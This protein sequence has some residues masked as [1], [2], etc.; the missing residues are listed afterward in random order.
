M[1]HLLKETFDESIIIADQK[2]EIERLRLLLNEPTAANEG[3]Q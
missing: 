1:S 3:P 2:V